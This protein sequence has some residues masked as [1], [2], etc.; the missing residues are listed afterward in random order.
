MLDRFVTQI[1]PH[2]KDIEQQKPRSFLDFLDCHN[3]ILLG[4][5]G[6]GKTHTFRH[7][8]EHEGAVYRTV[9]KFVYFDGE[10]CQGKTVYLDAL[11]EFRSRRGDK[12]MVEQIVHVARALDRPKIRLSCQAADWLGNT[13]LDIFHELAR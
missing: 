9:R 8:A 2:P 3:I 1:D 6:S 12:S 10:E 7:A 5:P 11:D 13:D 4:D